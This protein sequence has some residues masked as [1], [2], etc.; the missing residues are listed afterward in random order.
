MTSLLR[1]KEKLKPGNIY[2]DTVQFIRA[3][4]DYDYWLI[5]VKKNEDTISLIINEALPDFIKE[6]KLEIKWKMDSIR[7]AGD[8]GLLQYRAVLVAVSKIKSP[9]NDFSKVE[10]QSFV[11]SCGSGCAMTYNVKDITIINPSVKVTFDVELYIDEQRSEKFTEMYIFHYGN[12]NTIQRITP[13]GEMED[14][15]EIL[16]ENAQ[17]SF[18]DFGAILFTLIN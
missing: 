4:Y 16:S 2:S 9:G 6:E 12:I 18:K 5:N 7:Y 11:V 14:V 8:T 3:D 15:S 13:E 1:P 17:Q 10:K